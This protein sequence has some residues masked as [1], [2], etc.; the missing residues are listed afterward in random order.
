LEEEARQVKVKPEI[1][2]PETEA[3]REFDR[4]VERVTRILYI[5]LLE[6]GV[7]AQI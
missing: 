4:T 7:A 2:K 3:L 1:V 5:K 6:R